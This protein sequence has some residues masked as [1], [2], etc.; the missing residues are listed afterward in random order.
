M[1]S[2][3]NMIR[4]GLLTPEDRK[5]LVELARNGSA[6]HRHGRC[7]NAPGAILNVGYPLTRPGTY[8]DP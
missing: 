7:A 1:D 6:G 8:H 2:D 3:L 5:D 4:G